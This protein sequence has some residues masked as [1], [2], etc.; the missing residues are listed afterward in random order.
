[1]RH[2]LS[3]RL[4]VLAFAAALGGC[5]INAPKYTLAVNNVQ[6]LRDAGDARVKVG[7]VTAQGEEAN[8]ESIGLRGSP[9][10]SPYGS[11]SNYLREALTQELREAKM[12]D[13]NAQIEISAVLLKNDVHAAGFVTASAEIEARFKVI[14]AGQAAYDKVKSARIEWGSNF[15]GSIAIPRAQQH[16]PELVTALAAQLYAD[17]DF[18]AVLKP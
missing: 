9:M 15:I 13:E 10:R 7:S 8:D 6:A 17:R 11:Y 14:R 3:V 4:S 2:P 5:S 1:M 12:L 16:Y 18:L